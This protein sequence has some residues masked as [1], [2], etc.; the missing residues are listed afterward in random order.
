MTTIAVT[1]AT[2][3]LGRLIIAG[4]RQRRPADTIIALARDP[5][6]AADLAA[7]FGVVVRAF[8]YDQ[9]DGLA[10]ALVGVDRLLLISGSEIGRRAAQHRAVIGA[11]ATAGVGE[12]VY[13]SLLHAD[14]ST[15]SL[16]DEHRET[17]AALAQSGIPHAI[18]RN[19]WYLENYTAGVPGAVAGGA[20]L[21][22][23]GEGRISAAARADYAEAAAVVVASDGQ[24]GKVFELAGDTAFT[25]ADLAAEVSR[26]TGKPIPYR[27]LAASDYAAALEGFGFPAPVAAA[28][29]G[30][31]VSASEDALFD[32]G[33]TLSALIGRPTTSL[34]AAV[35]AALPS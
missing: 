10:A 5:A 24:A 7:D 33:G 30:F 17:E 16:A 18:L 31:D 22:S 2:G 3:Q 23:A 20:L 34:A 15:I 19:G 21:G 29:A 1:G 11:A 27:N 25:L 14:R 12:V 26:Q 28:Y 35:T 8:D 9:P 4:L 13:T 32:D 6:R